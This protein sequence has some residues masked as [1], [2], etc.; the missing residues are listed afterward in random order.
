[1]PGKIIA[2]PANIPSPNKEN[3]R[4]TLGCFENVGFIFSFEW[5]KIT[6]ARHTKKPTIKLIQFIFLTF[7]ISFL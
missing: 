4:P 7:W 6:M 2:E 3:N 1:M 5:I